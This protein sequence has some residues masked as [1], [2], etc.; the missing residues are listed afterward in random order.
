MEN[1]D[2]IILT[3]VVAIA[4]FVF[5]IVSIRELVKMETTEYRYNPNGKKYGRDAIYNLLE[6]LF[7]DD[8]ISKDSKKE[9][10]K[11]LER[12]ISDMET[13]GVYFSDDV[14]EKIQKEKEDLYCEYSGLPSVKSYV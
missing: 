13:D 11:T 4:F 10:I 7:E 1:I 8:T 12:N 6:K 5:I 2:I 14:I 3:S 9:I